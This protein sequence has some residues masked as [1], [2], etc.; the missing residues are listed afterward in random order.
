MMG[1]E[2]IN[3]F[4]RQKDEVYS[5]KYFV[6]PNG[7]EAM[8]LFVFRELV[9]ELLPAAGTSAPLLELSRASVVAP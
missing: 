1:F 8:I 5:Q 3:R 9:G 2:G 7:L 4:G 6:D